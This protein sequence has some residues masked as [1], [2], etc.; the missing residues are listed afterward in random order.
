MTERP[1]KFLFAGQPPIRQWMTM[2][3]LAE[4]GGFSSAEAARHWLKRNPEMPF[5]KRGRILLVDRAAFD[6]YVLERGRR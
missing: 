6:R 2:A 3:E 5:A 4:H 1:L